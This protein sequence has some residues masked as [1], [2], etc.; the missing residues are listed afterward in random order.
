MAGRM[1]EARK[2]TP[3]IGAERVAGPALRAARQR[4]PQ[5]LEPQALAGIVATP[6]LWSAALALLSP[7]W[8]V[9]AGVL[10]YLFAPPLVAGGCGLLAACLL[11]A[12]GRPAASAASLALLHLVLAIAFRHLGRQRQ[13]LE[14]A[15]A[16]DAL[17]RTGNR[18]ALWQSLRATHSLG[19]R[20]GAAMALVMLDI[21]HFKAVNERH[22][23][24]AGDRV[25]RRVAALC[26]ARLREHDRLFRYGGEE[27][28]V[29]LPFTGLA[30]ARRVAESLR[31]AVAAGTGTEGAGVTLSAGVAELRPGE[32]TALWL[33]R[34]DAALRRAKRAG[35]DRIA[36]AP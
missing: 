33:D 34:A 5:P 31:S 17:T 14:Q 16:Q 10:P 21:D 4:L 7:A 13:A 36:T 20:Q 6:V 18:R 29:L 9:P 19:R 30:D 11:G 35:R 3:G 15:A 28:V 27:F 12:S 22:G 26:A 23:H 1:D 24:L 32:S 25:L 8:L 2:G